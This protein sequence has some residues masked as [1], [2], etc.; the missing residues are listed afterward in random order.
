MYV[1][2][3]LIHS[4][5]VLSVAQALFTIWMAVDVYRRG[6][7]QFWY[8][9]ILF[10][11]ALGA[12]VYFFAVVA[13]NLNLA[14]KPHWLQRKVSL[15]ELRYRAE[16]TPTL[17]NNLALG[18]GL[19]DKGCFAEAIPILD[20]ARKIEPGHGS[21][22]Y[23]LA[24]CHTGQGNFDQAAELLQRIIDRDPRWSDYAAWRLLIE[25]H[26]DA[27]LGDTAVL[28]A[29]ELVKMAPTLRHKCILGEILIDQGQTEEARTL[30][31]QALQDH[32][33]TPATLRRPG[34][35]WAKQARRLLKRLS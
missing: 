21:V 33:F 25:T 4:H 2:T 35:P 16:R 17:A 18:E 1:I 28:K 12:W 31:D 10:L 34:R 7:E 29:R 26:Q 14:G 23:A 27:G 19:I 8:W 22:L 5:P 13:P 32:A 24:R 15:A 3:E 6:A 9:V 11:P 30:L 20:S